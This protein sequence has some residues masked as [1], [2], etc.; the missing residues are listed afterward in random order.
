MMEN[1]KFWRIGEKRIQVG[2]GSDKNNNYYNHLLDFFLISY[3]QFLSWSVTEAPPKEP[4]IS[5]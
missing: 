5:M 2:D 1:R 3:L 4:R